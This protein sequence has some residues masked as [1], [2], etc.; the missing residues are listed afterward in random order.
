[1]P[2]IVSTIA[3][4][5]ASVKAIAISTIAAVLLAVSA[6]IAF[7]DAGDRDVADSRTVAEQPFPGYQADSGQNAV[8]RQGSPFFTDVKPARPRPL[9]GLKRVHYKPAR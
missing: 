3:Q 9:H 5:K 4:P 1:M 7:A 6:S 2:N 8:H